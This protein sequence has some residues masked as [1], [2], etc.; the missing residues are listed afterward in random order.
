MR[1]WLVSTSGGDFEADFLINCGGLHCD[2]ISSMA[3]NHDATRIVPFR[4]E[5]YKF[6]PES[7]HLVRNLIYPVPDPSSHFWVFILRA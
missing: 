7:Q 6:R 1:P 5:Y 4:G 2:R 3:G